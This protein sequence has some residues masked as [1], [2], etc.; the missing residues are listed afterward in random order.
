MDAWG[1]A[2]IGGV[3]AAAGLVALALAL[4]SCGGAAQASCDPTAEPRL[5]PSGHGAAAFTMGI[6]I[7]R[8][9]DVDEVATDLGDRIKDRDVFVINTE[10]PHSKPSDWEQALER[11][12]EKFPCNR[13]A[14]LTGLS[15]N[16]NRPAYEFALV[17]H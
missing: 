14:T 10:Y 9:S 13:T 5:T 15:P 7:N 2:R 12:T 6:R 1:K 8:A 11:L 16:P 17:N 4:A 3:I